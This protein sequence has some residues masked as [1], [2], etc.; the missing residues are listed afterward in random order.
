MLNSDS[1]AVSG[2]SG[3]SA[4]RSS[5]D[6]I[7][8]GYGATRMS[9][10]PAT[11]ARMETDPIVQVL[12]EA[13]ERISA[14]QRAAEAG[15]GGGGLEEGGGGEELALQRDVPHPPEVWPPRPQNWRVGEL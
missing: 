8:C 6:I 3:Y 11:G 10:S 7:M 12:L 13:M 5:S 15:A 4:E 14:C 2:L 9:S 1:L